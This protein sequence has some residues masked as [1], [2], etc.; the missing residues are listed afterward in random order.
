MY[1][2]VIYVISGNQLTKK[3]SNSFE[4]IAHLQKSHLERVSNLWQILPVT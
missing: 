2:D 4:V 1:Q 3:G